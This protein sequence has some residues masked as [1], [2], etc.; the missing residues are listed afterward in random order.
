M[1]FLTTPTRAVTQVATSYR[2][3]NWTITYEVGIKKE[4]VHIIN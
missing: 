3:H 2:V 1:P 4:T